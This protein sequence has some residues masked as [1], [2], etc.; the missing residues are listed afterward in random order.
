[1]GSSIHIGDYTV[2]GI[3]ASISTGVNIGKNCIISV[4]STVMKDVPDNSIVEGVP[5]KII[6]T[7]KK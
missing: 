6:G 1:M 4:G 7:V 2:V 3:G 5:G